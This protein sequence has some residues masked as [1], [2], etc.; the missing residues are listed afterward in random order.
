MHDRL[1]SL[2][3]LLQ[4]GDYNK[5]MEALKAYRKEFP[6][7]W[8][9]K[10]MEGLVAQL[11]GDEMTFRRIHNEY[12]AIIDKHDEQAVKIQASPLWKTYHSLWK[13]S[14]NPF[15]DRYKRQ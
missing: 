11:R 7:Y 12:R 15:S 1:G 8:D 14:Y 3:Q 6:D 9:G 13:K 2:K 10:L 4:S 5:A